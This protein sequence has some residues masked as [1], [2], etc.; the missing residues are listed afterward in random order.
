MSS[1]ERTKLITNILKRSSIF[2]LP[3]M[4]RVQ[5]RFYMTR[6]TFKIVGIDISIN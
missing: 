1:A 2:M 5:G 3:G 4:M 6:V